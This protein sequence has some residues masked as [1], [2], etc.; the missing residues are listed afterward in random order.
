[1]NTTVTKNVKKPVKGKKAVEKG[2][3]TL[4]G[5]CVLAPKKQG[6]TAKKP[7]VK[8]AAPKQKVA[9]RTIAVKAKTK[10]SCPAKKN[11]VVRK[12][13]AKGKLF[14]PMKQG[15]RARHVTLAINDDEYARIKHAQRGGKSMSQ[16]INEAIVSKQTPSLNA[17]RQCDKNLSRNVSFWMTY[18]S[19][20]VLRSLRSSRSFIR[21]RL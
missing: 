7:A 6:K 10:G 17:L 16:V 21:A 14:A 1:M 5:G 11:P 9:V 3:F 8:K 18:S 19:Y 12:G 20:V 13:D 15:D 4:G 2:E